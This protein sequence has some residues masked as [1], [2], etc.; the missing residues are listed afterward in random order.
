[1]YAWFVEGF[2]HAW[3]WIGSYEVLQ[4]PCIGHVSPIWMYVE[5]FYAKATQVAGHVLGNA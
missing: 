5:D 1:M 4:V 3:F 2:V